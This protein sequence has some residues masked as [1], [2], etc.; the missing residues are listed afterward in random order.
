MLD[1]GTLSRALGGNQP[2]IEDVARHALEIG[3]RVGASIVGSRGLAEDVAQITAIQTLGH[4]GKLRDPLRVDAWIARTAT[5]ASLQQLRKPH[6]RRE[7]PAARSDELDADASAFD[8]VASGGELQAALNRLPPR[9]R[10][11][12][13][14]RYVLDL[15]DERIADALGCRVGTVRALLS[16]SRSELRT[17]PQLAPLRPRAAGAASSPVNH[18]D[19]RRKR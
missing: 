13:A 2:A 8:E 3:L 15:D 1:S 4:L 6:T 7:Q 9:Q 17:D 16:R 19:R 10:A 18:R 5:T 12:L 11:A 14:L